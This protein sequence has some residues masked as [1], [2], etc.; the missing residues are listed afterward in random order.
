MSIISIIGLDIAKTRFAVHCT[1]ASGKELKKAELKRGEV[2]A[3][4]AKLAPCRVGIEACGSAHHWAREIARL[5]HDV[6]L[7]AASRVKSFVLRQ[8]N[9]AAD[10]RAIVMALTHPDFGDSALY[11]RIIRI[12][13]NAKHRRLERGVPAR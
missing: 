9:D 2:L 5:G 10:A 11:S 12:L 3:F 13:T 6:R 8:K 7:I 1:D 4:F